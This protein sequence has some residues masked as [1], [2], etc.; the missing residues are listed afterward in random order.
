M[1]KTSL[2]TP[3][4][5][6]YNLLFA[7]VLVV[8]AYLR[9]V[10][11]DWDEDQ[12]LHPDERF[13]TGVV[14]SLDSVGSLGEYFDTANSSL[15]PNNRGSGFFVYG[16]LPIFALHYTGEAINTIILEYNRLFVPETEQV[17]FS[18]SGYDQIMLVGR[19][20]SALADL[21]VV[22]LV[23][24]IGTRLAG[25]RVGLLAAVFSAYA[26]MQIQQSHYWTVDNFVNFFSLLALL[27]AVRI[28]GYGSRTREKVAFNLWEF[29]GFGLALGLALASKI[30]VVPLAL[31]L[32]VAVALRL[33]SLPRE[34]R[35]T[36]FAPAFWWMVL[37]AGLS[38]LAFRVFQPYA[39]QGLGLAG[40]WSNIGAAWGQ[41]EGMGMLDKL[42]ELV[43]AFMGLNPHWVDTMASLSAQVSGDADW[44]P[45][46]QWARRPLWFGLQNIV[47]WGLGWPLALVCLAGF[48]WVGWR[49]YKGDWRKPVVVL[50]G[51]GA[52]YFLWQS[53]AFNPTMRYFLPF[54][55]ALV[56]CGAWGLIRLWD[57]GG[58]R[59]KARGNRGIQWQAWARPAAALAGVVAVLGAALWA[60]AFVQIYRQDVSRLE[61][62]RWI[63]QNLPGPIT[64]TVM[65]EGRQAHDPLPV[66]YQQIIS[67]EAPYFTNYFPREDGV[68]TQVAFK[69][70]LAP[71]LLELNSGVGGETLLT[72]LD[73]VVDL[74]G[75]QPGE[76]SQLVFEFQTDTLADPAAQYQLLLRLPAG[77]GQLQVT[78]IELRS[79]QVADA[80]GQTLL[81]ESIELRMGETLPLAFTNALGVAAD[82]LIF[83][84]II[85]E[86]ISM[87]PVKARLTLTAA[88]GAVLADHG[89]TLDVSTSTAEAG[90]QQVVALPEPIAVNKGQLL[91]LQLTI[92]TGEVN[93]LGTAVAN[94][95]SWDDGLPRRM[96]G[97]DGF[98][99]IY[100][101]DLNF[102]MYWDSDA[103]KLERF[104]DILDRAE[105]IFISSSRQWGSLPRIPERFPLVVAYYRAL[106]GC[107]E[108]RTIESCFNNAQV[109]NTQSEFG[110]ELVQVFE[111]APQLGPWIIND[112]AAE[113]AFTV[114]DHPKVLIFRK[115]ADFNAQAWATHLGQ[116]DLTQVVRVTPKQAAGGVLPNLM[117]PADRAEQQ[118]AGGTWSELFDTQAWINSS[119]WVSALAWYVALA[120]LGILVYPLVRWTLPGLSDGGYAFARLVGLLLLAYLA[121]MGGSLGLAF[122][123]GWLAAF[124]L[125]LAIIGGVAAWVQREGLRQEW[126]TRR[127][128]FLRVEG[129]FLAFFLLML[130]IRFAN[131]DLWHPSFGGEK[132]MDFSY[133]NAVLKSTSFPP[134]DPW[135]AG[136][137]INYYYYGFV[138]VG[139]LVKLLGI[140]P[141]VA[142]NLILPTLFA[143]L[144]LG[145]YSLA[146]NIWMAWKAREG[147]AARISPELVGLAA[148]GAVLILGNLGSISMLLDAYARLGAEGAYA[149]NSGLVNQFVWTARGLFMSLS[150]QALPVGRGN[151]YWDPTRIIPAPGETGPITE[152]P[153]FT[154]VYADLHAHMIALPVTVLGLAWSLSAVLSRAWVGLKN[155]WQVATSLVLGAI[156]L[157][158]LRPI[159]TWDLPTYLAIAML[160]VGYSVWRYGP[161]RKGFDGKLRPSWKLAAGGMGMLAILS[162]IAYQPFVA[163]YR[164]GYS[165]IELWSG[166][167]TPTSPYI[168]H[169]GIFLFFIVAWLVWETR[170]WMASTPL[171]AL[172][173]LERVQYQLIAAAVTI[174][175]AWFLLFG[176]GV[177]V[178]WLVYPLLIWVGLIFFRPGLD[179]TKRLVVFLVG[180][181][182]FLT[183]MVEVIRLQGDISRMNTVFKFYMQAWVL[184]AVS[185]SLALAW[186]LEA[187]RHWLPAWRGAWLLSSAFLMGCG[188]LFMLLGVSAKVGDRM[189]AEAPQ[190]L[191]GMAYMQD[192]IYFDRDQQL[193]LVNDF[194]AIRWMQENVQGSPVIIEAHTGEY[195]WGSRFSINTGLPSII[196]WNWHQ[197][198][199]REF[200]AGNDIW[201]RVAEVENFYLTTDL[202]LVRQTLQKYRV[203]YIVLGQLEHAYYPGPGLVKFET[204]EGVLWRV[205]YRQGETV[206]YK[207]L[208]SAL[209]GN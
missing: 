170:Q 151:W 75:L 28:A 141:A 48:G 39:F 6:I 16:T 119:P 196:G 61:A 209:S 202:E 191:D 109:E 100:Q 154:F 132:P 80:P 108:E 1:P 113:E 31:T 23:F 206:I 172:R 163:W 86:E 145:A 120:A 40:W 34:E 162:V 72:L 98:G 74:E 58:S 44:P 92:E 5:W 104:L 56:I 192:A 122:S 168:I 171:S 7:L 105:Y 152:F 37:A 201:G 156:I 121:W 8:A 127:L 55:P 3:R 147:R 22:A 30:S 181:G 188:G 165:S 200:V 149:P 20:L 95:S 123:R 103:T 90:S 10:G 143:M 176:L 62:T 134:Y 115:T 169:W 193:D 178:A 110:F 41:S 47:G 60:W 106:I 83:Q 203:A 54:Y 166:T 11:I 112:Q 164:Q 111:N 99:G 129:L 64:M 187:L 25:K 43:T 114:Y 52:F 197:R 51:W 14:A 65:Q 91:G 137:Y 13:L 131:P 124:V 69:H 82:N 130:V 136:G 53:I 71:I 140:V 159:N 21:G 26:V 27:F 93:L 184:L 107:P 153:L 133:F 182:L 148:A 195:R 161:K 167:H 76:S 63:Y 38:A 17:V 205:V 208:D 144:A 68:L 87:A 33:G 88:D 96:D 24:A 45:S 102:E 29:V 35:A 128:T 118:Q 139:S 198:Q 59:T 12:H 180:T 50:W 57:A 67:P 19:A 78:A 174:I 199:Q 157:G 4:S 207:V 150:G 186:T 42:K 9:L 18:V 204:Q 155:M 36:Q 146:W 126:Q 81:S 138:L 79:S 189:A 125:V 97:Y 94:E 49:I 70:V 101:G 179:E 77:R 89:L 194:E 183:L 85:T 135:F 66:S 142:Y 117:L 15:N 190:N 84:F 32:P 160:A 177:H 46:M 73:Q 116:V 2:P 173:K 158:S 175:F 185:A